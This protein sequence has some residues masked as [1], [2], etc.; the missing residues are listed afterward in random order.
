MF[1]VADG[2]LGSGLN[3]FADGV[4]LRNGAAVNQDAVSY[5][6]ST[7]A[8]SPSVPLVSAG[9]SIS[10]SP[11]NQDNNARGDWV[12]GA[13]NPGEGTLRFG[14]AS[15]SQ[16]TLVY[17]IEI[18][19]GSPAGQVVTVAN[20]RQP[21]GGSVQ[22]ALAAIFITVNPGDLTITKSPNTQSAGVGDIVVWTVTVKNEGFGNAPNVS[23]SDPLGGGFNF[24]S[25]GTNPTN[26][27]PYGRSVT[28]DSTV[29]PA[30][31]IWPPSSR[32]P[33]W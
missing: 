3:N 27:P 23:I 18:A 16:I 4:F 9:Q 13:P 33:L 32:C 19:C 26:V 20:Y 21:A 28:W 12:G 30:L 17:E 14:L 7:A 25:F 5:G 2:T 24:I 31:R 6:G 8:F 1:Q 11:A 10:R 15:G 29:I 22:E